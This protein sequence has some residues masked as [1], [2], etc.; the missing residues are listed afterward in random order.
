VKLVL[1][2]NP[3]L[4]GRLVKSKAPGGELGIAYGSPTS[5][6]DVF[7]RPA[8]KLEISASTS[9]DLFGVVDDLAAAGLL[10][11]TGRG[12]IDQVHP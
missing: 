11:A 3:W 12:A 1:K 6:S 4:A 9:R 7:I 5:A 2:A 10:G 8:L